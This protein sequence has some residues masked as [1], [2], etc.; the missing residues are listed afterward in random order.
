MPPTMLQLCGKILDNAFQDAARRR[1][2]ASA[3]DVRVRHRAGAAARVADTG[4]GVW[5]A[6]LGLAAV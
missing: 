1:R 2:P 4:N 5:M 6:P 3:D